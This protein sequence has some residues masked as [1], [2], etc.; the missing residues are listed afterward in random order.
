MAILVDSIATIFAH[1]LFTEE[2]RLE[3]LVVAVGYHQVRIRAASIQRTVQGTIPIFITGVCSLNHNFQDGVL[4]DIKDN[5]TG[6]HDLV[7]FIEGEH[8]GLYQSM[9]LHR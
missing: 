8:L 6:S 5:R 7:V 4:I 9:Q 1:G 3:D 2:V